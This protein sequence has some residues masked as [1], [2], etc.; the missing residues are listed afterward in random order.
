MQAFLSSEDPDIVA[1]Q[2][3]KI[4]K[5]MMSNELIPEELGYDIL[6]RTGTET[7]VVLCY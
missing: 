6:G 7:A 1:I 5:F 3:T 4:D 2:E